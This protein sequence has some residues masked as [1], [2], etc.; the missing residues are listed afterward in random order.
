MTMLMVVVVD[1][2]VMS[3][4]VNFQNLVQI[5]RPSEVGDREI[6][7]FPNCVGSIDGK[8]IA[9]KCPPNSGS[10]YFCHKHFFSIVLLAIVDPF[11]KFITVDIG[12][13]G[14]LSDSGI[15]ENSIFYRV[16]LNGKSLLP[17]KPPP[18]NE[19]T[20]PQVLIGDEGFAL[21]EYLMRPFLRA[22]VIHDNRKK[23]FNYR[24][25]RAR[26]VVKNSF[27][28]LA[29]KYRIF[30][31]PIESEVDIVDIVKD[32]NCIRVKGES[33]YFEPN[34]TP[35][36]SSDMSRAFTS[37]RSTNQRSPNAAFVVREMFVIYF[38]NNIINYK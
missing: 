9:I 14:R 26:R 2:I 21:K 8:H 6:W 1:Y 23:T 4:L 3:Y 29:R 16:Y 17:P 20:T 24:H 36:E 35:L 32:N 11:Y 38:N 33:F 34:E 31:R 28:I 19:D 22:A 15:F 30:H 10:N 25:C 18:G 37:K 13:Y 7:N 27:G 12:N 5:C